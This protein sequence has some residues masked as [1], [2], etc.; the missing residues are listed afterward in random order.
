MKTDPLEI[1]LNG[2]INN[3]DFLHEDL[4]RECKEAEKKHIHY[5]EFFSRLI[6]CTYISY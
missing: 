5:N 1:I 6:D 4:Y 2:Y 3:R